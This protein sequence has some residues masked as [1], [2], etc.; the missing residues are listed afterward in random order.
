MNTER[1]V[2]S[3]KMINFFSHLSLKKS[4]KNQTQC[5]SVNCLML[6]SS[7][8]TEQKTGA[9]IVIYIYFSNTYIVLITG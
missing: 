9:T 3:K 4:H 5:Q 7:Q 6:L 1:A 2:M 8:L